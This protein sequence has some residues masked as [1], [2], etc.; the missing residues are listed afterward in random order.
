MFSEG[1]FISPQTFYV[2][3]VSQLGI[4]FMKQ[5]IISDPKSSF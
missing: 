3:L 4:Y 2:D 1:K 5:T